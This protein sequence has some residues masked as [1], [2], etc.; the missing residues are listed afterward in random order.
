MLNTDFLGEYYGMITFLI[1]FLREILVIVMITLLKRYLSVEFV[2]YAASTCYGF[3][4][5]YGNKV[6]PLVI[7]IGLMLTIIT[8]ALFILEKIIL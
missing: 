4:S 8:P 1:D 7:T 3:L 6:V 5:K 2:G